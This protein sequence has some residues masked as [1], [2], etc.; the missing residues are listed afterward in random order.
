MYHR[1]TKQLILVIAL[2]AQSTNNWFFKYANGFSLSNVAVVSSY[3]ESSLLATS[4][5]DNEEGTTS[6]IR[7]AYKN[8]DIESDSDGPTSSIL[9]RRKR[10]WINQSLTYYATVSRE[11]KRRERGQFVPSQI[12]IDQHKSNFVT[13]KKLYFAR[14]KIKKNQP[15]HAERIYRKL[16]D[17]LL[18]EQE[19]GKTCDHAQIAIS[20]LLLALL[21]QRQGEIKETRATFIRFFRLI[22]MNTHEQG[23]L[24]ECTCSAKVLQAFALFEMKQRN[25][26]KAYNLIQMAVELDNELEPVLQW[27]QFQDAK[28]LLRR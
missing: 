23:E 6:S 12:Q 14:H 4:T 28:K 20:T 19:Q 5:N 17:D 1:Y 16:I 25:P 18:L 3:R 13:A 21:L 8:S 2:A 15:R 22:T 7:K 26:R 27:K 9:Q 24:E 11:A 10:E